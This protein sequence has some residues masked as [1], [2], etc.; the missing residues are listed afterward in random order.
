MKDDAVIAKIRR[1]RHRISARC[2]H[3]PKRLMEHYRKFEQKL[4]KSGKFRFSDETEAVV[5]PKAA[6]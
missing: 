2:G 3:D 6:K 1:A 4:R 5:T